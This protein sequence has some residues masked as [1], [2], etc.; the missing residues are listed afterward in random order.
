MF[1]KIVLT[2]P[3][4]AVTAPTA[5]SAMSATSSAFEQVLTLFTTD[6]RTNG[7]DEFHGILQRVVPT[8]KNVFRNSDHAACSSCLR[9][10]PGHIATGVHGAPRDRGACS[11]VVMWVRLAMIARG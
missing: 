4:A 9:D 2:L 7:V 11:Q 5:T 3:P 10:A 6:E 8:R 1:V